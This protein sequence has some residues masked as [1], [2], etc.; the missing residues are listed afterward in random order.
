MQRSIQL[1]LSNHKM[2][3]NE[4]LE[5]HR[6]CRFAK[7]NMQGSK[8][9]CNARIACMSRYQDILDVFGFGCRKLSAQSVNLA[10]PGGRSIETTDFNFGGPF[11][12]FLEI[13]HG[14]SFLFLLLFSPFLLSWSNWA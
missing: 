13:G 8:D 12:G 1:T 10:L 11:Y 6:P 9:L 2:D 7:S 4:R 14:G 3:H 5:H